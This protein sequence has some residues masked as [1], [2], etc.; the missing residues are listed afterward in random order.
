MYFMCVTFM[1]FYVLYDKVLM[2]NSFFVGKYFKSDLYEDV[3]TDFLS[4]CG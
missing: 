3:R 2:N 4:L 1:C